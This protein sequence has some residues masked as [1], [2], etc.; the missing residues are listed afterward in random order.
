[1]MGLH[2]IFIFYTVCAGLSLL[3]TFWVGNTSLKAPKL[4][5]SVDE[6]ASEAVGDEEAGPQEQVVSGHNAGD[7]GLDEKK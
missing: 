4:P 6:A 1:M 2:Y 7:G 3:L 5:E